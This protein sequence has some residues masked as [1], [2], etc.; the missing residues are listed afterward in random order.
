ML[1]SVLTDTELMRWV[2]SSPSDHQAK[3]EL[4]R[5]STIVIDGDSARIIELEDHLQMLED[6]CK[7]YDLIMRGYEDV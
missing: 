7:E 2:R 5:R 3:T 1:F 4:L 6:R